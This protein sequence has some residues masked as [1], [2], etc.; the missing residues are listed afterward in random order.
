MH[1]AFWVSLDMIVSSMLSTVAFSHSITNIE[2]DGKNVFDDDEQ[3]INCI[4]KSTTARHL[5]LEFDR[6]HDLKEDL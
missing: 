3:A 4:G 1:N 6:L 2:I 5:G